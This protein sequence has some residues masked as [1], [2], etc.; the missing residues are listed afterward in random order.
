MNDL[1]QLIDQQYDFLKSKFI[2][3]TGTSMSN[4]NYF[5]LEPKRQSRNKI[6]TD[7]GELTALGY[8]ITVY[9]I[10][11]DNLHNSTFHI[12]MNLIDENNNDYIARVYYKGL[13]EYLFCTIKNKNKKPFTLVS[14][15]SLVKFADENIASF[16]KMFDEFKKDYDKRYQDLVDLTTKQNRAIMNT[17]SPQ[18][19]LD[20]R[21]E[22]Q[23]LISHI[24]SGTLF[25]QKHVDKLEHYHEALNRI[26]QKISDIDKKETSL[27]TTPVQCSN[28]KSTANKVVE[29]SNS[30]KIDEINKEISALLRLKNITPVA[31]IL[32][33]HEL[34]NKKRVLLQ[35]DAK[36]NDRKSSKKNDDLFMDIVIRC[37]Q[38]QEDINKHVLHF[39]ND[40]KTYKKLDPQSMSGLLEKCN[41]KTEKLVALA[42]NNNCV[43]ALQQLMQLRKDINLELKI[44][45]SSE[46]QLIVSAPEVDE[47]RNR[48]AKNEGSSSSIIPAEANAARFFSQSNGNNDDNH[49]QLGIT[50]SS[51][52]Q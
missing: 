19:L 5:V 43:L 45:Y 23:H 1:Y 39:L 49:L 33:E 40:K 44:Q 28:T 18:K 32:Q 4:S 3:S 35:K 52:G 2:I 22:L 34:Q 37:N 26:D 42:I 21:Q 46:H 25:N 29:S 8:H 16:V 36:T 31:K 7:N 51:M 48:F 47:A 17:Q 41:L 24:E 11:E 12:T 30:I 15:D 6:R 14:Q 27:T 20:Y 13:D 38:L 9:N 10:F 50:M